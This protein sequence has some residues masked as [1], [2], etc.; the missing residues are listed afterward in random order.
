MK[1]CGV[2]YTSNSDGILS[3][4]H[5]AKPTS[6]WPM[7]LYFFFTFSSWPCVDQKRFKKTH[8]IKPYQILWSLATDQAR[9]LNSG[10]LTSD[11]YACTLTTQLKMK[12][13]EDDP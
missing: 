2:G 5:H 3:L 10:T 7:P 4:G 12:I 13:S 1:N 8:E 9:K 11:T 6:T